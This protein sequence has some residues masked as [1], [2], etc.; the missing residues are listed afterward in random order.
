[1]I[2]VIA[3]IEIDIVRIDDEGHADQ[4]EHLDALR[5]AIDDVTVEYVG[6]FVRWQSVLAERAAE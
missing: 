5:A 3:A 2:F 1:M 6:I 4:Q